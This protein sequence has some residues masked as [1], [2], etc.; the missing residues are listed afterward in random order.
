MLILRRFFKI[1]V[2]VGIG[3]GR[4][5]PCLIPVGFSFKPIKTISSRSCKILVLLAELSLK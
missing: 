4:I 2:F 1:H 5:N 3:S